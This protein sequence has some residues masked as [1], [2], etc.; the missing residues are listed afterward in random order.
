[1]INILTE[2][3]FFVNTKIKKNIKKNIFL[4]F[5]ENIESVVKGSPEKHRN[6]PGFLDDESV[7]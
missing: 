7:L 3:N 1:M 4:K 5:I 6:V 2:V